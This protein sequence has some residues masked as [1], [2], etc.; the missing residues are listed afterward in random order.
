MSPNLEFTTVMMSILFAST[1]M[2][3]LFVIANRD[4]A[5]MDLAAQV[6]LHNSTIAE[7]IIYFILYQICVHKHTHTEVFSI[8][9]CICVCVKPTFIFKIF[10]DDIYLLLDTLSMS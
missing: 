4:T 6:Y 9:M 10:I 8:W 2:G 3:R 7:V 1:H 5:T